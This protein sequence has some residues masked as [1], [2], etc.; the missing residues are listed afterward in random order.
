MGELK[1]FNLNEI[2]NRLILDTLIK[3]MP[4]LPVPEIN[5]THIIKE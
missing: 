1:L 3:L 4:K 2:K 5:E